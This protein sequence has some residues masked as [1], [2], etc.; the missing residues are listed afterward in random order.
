[1]AR[2]LWTLTHYEGLFRRQLSPWCKLRGIHFV[3]E[4]TLDLLTKFR[5]SLKNLGTVK[6]RKL[7]RV[8]SF[9]EFCADRRWVAT[10]VAKKIK[11]S[12]E[13]APDIDYFQP[14]EMNALENA[15]FISH[16]W[17]RGRDYEYR[18][19]R[20]RAFILFARWTGLSIIDCV[21]FERYRLRR[22]SDGVWTVL[23]RRMK[24]GNP[25]FV[26]V[27]PKV[28]E[29]LN[30][31]PPVSD[32][33]FFWTGNGRPQTAVRGWRR[34][35][36]HVFKAAK[37][38]RSGKFLRCHP[39]M[40]RHTFAIEKLLGGASLEDVSLLLGHSSTKVTE[41]HYLKFDQRRQDRLVRASMSDWEQAESPKPSPAKRAKV[42]RMARTTD[43][44]D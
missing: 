3:D 21:R 4:L 26:A 42:L 13:E 16:R 31:I 34:S 40:F 14:E 38:K 28:I 10:N 23:L 35:L 36:E 44:G 37:L 2:T 20:L 18:D 25:V 33:Y 17:E 39:H 32:Q 24:N 11:R 19:K 5:N 9:C 29:A 22:N 8:R 6:N 1:V 15:C 7:S 27:P 43:A 30:S 41:R 12:Q